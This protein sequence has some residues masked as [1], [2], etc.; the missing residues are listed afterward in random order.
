MDFKEQ[1]TNGIIGFD[2]STNK[3][4]WSAGNSLEY[5]IFY[6]RSDKI[7]KYVRKGSHSDIFNNSVMSIVTHIIIQL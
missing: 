5:A 7:C 2:N 1:T 4:N 3:R 6:A